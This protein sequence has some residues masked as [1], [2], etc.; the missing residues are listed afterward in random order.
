MTK[1][2]L[3]T[4]VPRTAPWRDRYGTRLPGLSALALENWLLRDE[5]FA[6]QMALRD[7]LIASRRTDVIAALPQAEDAAVECL[8]LVLSALDPGYTLDGNQVVR[9]D[10]VTVR[11]NHEDPL[12]TIGRLVQCDMCLM[13][14]TPDGYALTA[15]VLCFPAS[16]TLSEKIGKPL[17]AIHLPVNEYDGQMAK[18]VERVFQAI[19]V[20]RLLTR[21][22]LLLYESPDLFAPRIEAD[23]RPILGNR[24]VRT[25][26]QSFRRL[27]RTNAVVFGIHTTVM[28]IEILPADERQAVQKA[29][30]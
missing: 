12:G 14:V 11:L 26:R 18:R 10:G 2:I 29:V 15:A 3:Q 24:Y 28:D 17:P 25:E 27:P 13:Q 30:S 9:P 19:Q 6:E 20:D 8:E 5:V 21:A 16:W 23:K 22:N 7:S 1:P 4:V